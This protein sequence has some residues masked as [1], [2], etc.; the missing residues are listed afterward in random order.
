MSTIK[1]TFDEQYEIIKLYDILR[2]MD[3]ELT[4]LQRSVF[5]KIQESKYN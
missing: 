5:D 2:D 3:F 1:L 4:D